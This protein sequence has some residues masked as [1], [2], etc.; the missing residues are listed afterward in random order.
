MKDSHA[1]E[2]AGLREVFSTIDHIHTLTRL[3]E[4][5]QEYKMP[6]WLKFFDLMKA[7]DIVETK[8]V[9][10]ALGYQ[11]VPNQYIRRL[12]ELR[13]NITT[14]ISPFYKE[15]IINEKRGVREGDTISPKLSVPLSR[16]SCVVR[17]LSTSLPL[18]RRHRAYNTNIEQAER[19]LAEFDSACGKIGLRLNSTKTMSIEKGLVSYA[20]FMLNITNIPQRFSYVHLGREVNMMN[21]LALELC[22]RK[23]AAWGAFKI[24]KD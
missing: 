19:M 20:P 10:E 3:I 14:R 1:S 13:D 24:S 22:R 2:Q 6:L 21:N 11:G 17:P 12:R 4:I 15:A 8:A 9:I 18:G 16:I 7:F 5:S 23:R